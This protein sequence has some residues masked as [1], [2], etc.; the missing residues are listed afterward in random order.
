MGKIEKIH[1]PYLD[2][3]LQNMQKQKWIMDATPLGFLEIGEIMEE[4]NTGSECFESVWACKKHKSECE[5]CD[6][7]FTTL[8]D[9][10]TECMKKIEQEIRILEELYMFHQYNHVGKENWRDEI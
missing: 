8:C 10:E 6:A 2:E 1:A 7:F 4:V 9:G 3:R 5:K